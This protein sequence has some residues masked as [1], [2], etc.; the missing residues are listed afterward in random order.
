[1][2]R[3]ALKIHPVSTAK[4]FDNPYRDDSDPRF[5]QSEIEIIQRMVDGVELC[6]SRHYHEQADAHVVGW[7]WDKYPKYPP[8]WDGPVSMLM[9]RGVIRSEKCAGGFTWMVFTKK[10]MKVFGLKSST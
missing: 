2:T 3:L 7:Y 9:S 1:M 5:T 4:K 6:Q 8:Q 10:A